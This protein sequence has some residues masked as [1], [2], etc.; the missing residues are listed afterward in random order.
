MKNKQKLKMSKR[1]G[2]YITM[3]DVIDKVGV[4]ALRF[5]MISRNSDKTIDFDFELLQKK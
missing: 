5:M 4:D 3:R 2:N 1:Q